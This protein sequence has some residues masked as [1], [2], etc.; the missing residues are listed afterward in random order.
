MNR[1]VFGLAAV[2]VAALLC[3]PAGSR[4][5]DKPPAKVDKK[6]LKAV[7]HVN[8]A[9]SDRQKH[10]LKNVTNVL[11]AEGGKAE[12]V[13][14]CHGGGIGLVVKGQSKHA[15]AVARLTREGVRFAA[16]ENT[17]RDR[18]IAKDRL[19]PGATTVPSGAVEVIRKQQEGYGYFKP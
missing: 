17:L 13:V 4:P 16:C 14:V 7:V 8:F 5:E 15:D 18:S 9:D 11:K 6:I 2:G 12:I 3:S 1:V 19:L 10:G